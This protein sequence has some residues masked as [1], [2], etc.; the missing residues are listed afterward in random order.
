MV[1]EIKQIFIVQKRE[2]GAITI[3]GLGVDNKMYLWNATHATWDPF[4]TQR[5]PGMGAEGY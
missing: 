3:Y 4:F 5:A 2:G 1:M